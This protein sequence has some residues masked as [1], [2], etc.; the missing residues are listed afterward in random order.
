[1]HS[2]VIAIVCLLLAPF[3]AAKCATQA[4]PPQ[5]P[6]KTTAPPDH[7]V[8]YWARGD[9]INEL[10]EIYACRNVSLIYARGTHDWGN[11][12][13]AHMWFDVLATRIGYSNLAVGG[14]EYGVAGW[15]GWDGNG[16]KGVAS[17]REMY[18]R[19]RRR[20]KDTQIVLGGHQRGAFV[21]KRFVSS[22][23]EAEFEDVTAGRS[24]FVVS[25]VWILLMYTVVLSADK[26][27]SEKKFG[28]SEKWAK[29][30]ESGSI[31][32]VPECWL[33][34]DWL[35]MT[36]LIERLGFHGK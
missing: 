2:K 32:I 6:A 13:H 11:V 34:E 10:D 7:T 36:W 31:Y 30:L 19:T 21:L 1:M 26:K 20:C 22:L 16:T 23:S 28:A 29:L 3:T 15:N 9:S 18:S 24:T 35:P 8:T 17:F 25:V 12:G 14:L 5:P 33:K 4:P 27:D